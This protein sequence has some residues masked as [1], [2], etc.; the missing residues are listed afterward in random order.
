MS[1]P[2][3]WP[4][5]SDGFDFPY[6]LGHSREL[7]RAR[8]RRAGERD[9]DDTEEV[10][11]G[12][13]ITSAFAW[14]TSLA[15]NL[16]FSLYDHLTYP[17]V[18]QVVSTDGQSWSFHV[19]QLNDY[20][21]HSDVTLQRPPTNICWS[22]GEMKLFEGVGEGSLTG[23]NDEVLRLIVKVS[24]CFLIKTFVNFIFFS[25]SPPQRKASSGRKVLNYGHTFPLMIDRRLI[26]TSSATR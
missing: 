6:L 12:A 26:K 19:Y 24:F 1:L 3:F 15:N 11:D 13:A 20:A 17:L 9:W 4:G 18:T 8:R 23:V 7:L 2:G 22:S 21:F 5:R 25:F 14:L 10:V 16:G